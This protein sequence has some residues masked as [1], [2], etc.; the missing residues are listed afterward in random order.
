RVVRVARALATRLQ[1]AARGR[2]RLRQEA[3][4]VSDRERRRIAADLHDG[5]VQQLAG[6][7]MHLSAQAMR[8]EDDAGAT[9]LGDAAEAVRASVRT[10]RS[11]IVGIYPPNLDAEGLRQE[12]SD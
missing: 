8:D 6:L 7:A 9:T 12:L 1:R 2:A 11:A 4:D 3:I 10:L 5:P